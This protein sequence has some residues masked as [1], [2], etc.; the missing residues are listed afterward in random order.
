MSHDLMSF[1]LAWIAAPGRVGA[2]APSGDALA[3]LI[4]RE[5]GSTTGAVVELGPGTGA[6]TYKLLKRGV[7]QKILLLSNTDPSS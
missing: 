7:R 3:E 1:F 6:I 2:I 5:I 4:T